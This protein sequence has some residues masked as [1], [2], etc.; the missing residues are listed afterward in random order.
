MTGREQP[1]EG[2]AEMAASNRLFNRLWTDPVLGPETH[3]RYK[4]ALQ[5]EIALADMLDIFDG[6][7]DDIAGGAR[8]D[9]RRWRAAYLKHDVWSSRTDFTDFDSE[10]QYMRQWIRERWAYLAGRFE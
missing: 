6:M 8:R 9:E 2:P 1:N 3:A 4:E 7:A 10:V 5:N